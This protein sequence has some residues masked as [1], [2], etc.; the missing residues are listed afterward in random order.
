MIPMLL[1]PRPKYSRSAD[2]YELPL[3]AEE[4]PNCKQRPVS[5]L[6][7]VPICIPEGGL[8]SELMGLRDSPVT[9][10]TYSLKQPKGN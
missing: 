3:H 9:T 8:P 1:S 5:G 6:A 2:P 4:L 7:D 10:P